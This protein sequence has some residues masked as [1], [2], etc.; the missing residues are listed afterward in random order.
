MIPIRGRF[1]TVIGKGLS[2]L[3]TG[4]Y[5]A[6][7]THSH[8]QPADLPFETV[9]TIPQ[10]VNASTLH[11]N[12]SRL[13]VF[14][15]DSS[16]GQVVWQKAQNGEVVKRFTLPAPAVA[17]SPAD[18]G[19][20]LYVSH[21]DGVRGKPFVSTQITELDLENPELSREITMPGPPIGLVANSNRV[22]VVV[23][24]R[25]VGL[26][27]TSAQ[28]IRLTDGIKGHLAFV[29]S[30]PLIMAP[31]GNS[32]F[33]SGFNDISSGI[34]RVPFDPVAL[35][36]GRRRPIPAESTFPTA[37]VGD[38]DAFVSFDWVLRNKP[39][40]ALEDLKR[41][42]AINGNPVVTAATDPLRPGFFLGTGLNSISIYRRDRW[43]AVQTYPLEGSTQCAIDGD[44]MLALRFQPVSGLYEIVRTS[45]PLVGL[46]TNTPPTPVIAVQPGG[47]TTARPTVL[48]ASGSTDV[49]SP[50]DQL[51]FRWDVDGDG[52]YDTPLLTSPTFA[53]RFGQAG[54]YRVRL[55]AQ[56]AAG[57]TNSVMREI[58]VSEEPVPAVAVTN[59]IPWDL[60]FKPSATAFDLH[61]GF[62]Y[63][64]DSNGGRLVRLSLTNGRTDRQ[65]LVD[66]TPGPIGIR[67]DGR[68]LYLAEL[69]ASMISSN[70]NTNE[71]IVEFDLEKELRGRELHLARVATDIVATDGGVV[72]VAS[73]VLETFLFSELRR[74]ESRS[75][76]A[77]YYAHLIL[78]PSQET[79]YLCDLS[80]PPGSYQRY[81]L[82]PLS[83]I[84]EQPYSSPNLYGNLVL[85]NRGSNFVTTSK[86][87]LEATPSGAADFALVPNIGFN[88][89]LM[90]VL[91]LPARG[92]FAVRTLGFFEFYNAKGQRV[93]VQRAPV[94]LTQL[95]ADDESIYEVRGSLVEVRRQPASDPAANR[96]PVID[97]K[98]LEDQNVQIGGSVNLRAVATDE[99]GMMARMEMLDGDELIASIDF[100]PPTNVPGIGTDPGTLEFTWTP[101]RGGNHRLRAVAVDNLGARTLSREVRVFVNLPPEVTM[102]PLPETPQLSPVSFVLHIHASDP[103]GHITAVEVRFQEDNAQTERPTWRLTEPPW[104]LPVN[105]LAGG[106]G[107]IWVQA[108]DDA[109]G[110]KLT[111]RI[112]NLTLPPGDDFRNPLAIE[113]T[114]GTWRANTSVATAQTEDRR[115]GF[116]P[117]FTQSSYWWTWTAP[118][119]LVVTLDTFGSSY[120][121]SLQVNRT[122]G[123]LGPQ[124]LWASND[125]YVGHEPQSLVRFEALAGQHFRFVV[126]SGARGEAG[127]VQLNL[128]TEPF[129]PPAGSA[130]PTND[131]AA[132]A[133][134]LTTDPNG[135]QGTTLGATLE[136]FERDLTGPTTN[137]VWY[138]WTAPERGV[139]ELSTDQ[140]TVDTK[141]LVGVQRGDT[142]YSLSQD[143]RS[144]SDRTSRLVFP[145]EKG[146]VCRIRLFGVAPRAGD[147]H[148]YLRFPVESPLLD[149]PLNDDLSSATEIDG[150]LV[151]LQ[152]QLFGATSVLIPGLLNRPD[153]WYR[154][155]APENSTVR[156]WVW[157]PTWSLGPTVELLKLSSETKLD[158]VSSIE[159]QDVKSTSVYTRFTAK[160]G[161]VFYIR[162]GRLPSVP[163][164]DFEFML[165]SRSPKPPVLLRP[166]RL[167]GGAFGLDLQVPFPRKVHLESTTDFRRW[168]PAGS[169]EVPA[170]GIVWPIPQSGDQAPQFFRATSYN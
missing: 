8:A 68:K 93:V 16:N 168:Y 17:L 158:P 149:S 134:A 103:D 33:A 150:S 45:N 43:E 95:A 58:A 64:V 143:D 141:L 54:T 7:G 106:P 128:K 98:N 94:A 87:F 108:F 39:T 132:K 14:W 135:Q 170:N 70:P 32:I 139:A 160:A 51:R 140:A 65:W 100:G 84:L 89:N 56:D 112:L 69:R 127:E 90:N 35:T 125:N 86:Q 72:V 15:I 99:D 126:Y 167:E 12:P 3:L 80:N 83:G 121:T 129:I 157:A 49:Q 78:H 23:F 63:A 73:D 24:P 153:V 46:E 22:A 148:L 137:T 104:D 77:G 28:L 71:F 31:E 110:S 145:V 102:D 79:L 114:Q 169:I 62:L 47:L 67:P 42:V 156:L 133:I 109:G 66:G 26:E 144:A 9:F 159:V 131:A 88:P 154:W 163:G 81:S 146:D 21:D 118:T 123:A 13:G 113:G 59:S 119:N 41:V 136:R 20:W 48:D 34:S 40:N 101:T 30:P 155:T 120:D 18:G 52:Q 96:P 124:F 164:F 152:G 161:E 27:G 19:R 29:S 115:E 138:I 111:A 130:P 5:L 91:D 61:R 2:L 117:S 4:L 57:E 82:G 162:V 166:G 85:V 147:F 36:F 165:D 75:L 53:Y 92:L 25:K 6:Y 60:G 151:R 1:S 107:R 55:E 122:L 76:G 142:T 10:P 97:W 11:L 50:L 116:C 38:P 74:V 44:R 105:G 37:F